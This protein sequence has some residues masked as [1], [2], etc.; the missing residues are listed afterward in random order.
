MR[1]NQIIC[2]KCK[3]SLTSKAGIEVGT[4]I[5]CPKCKSKFAVSAP[6]NQEEVYEDFEVVDDDEEETPKKRPA[7]AKPIAKKRDDDDEDDAPKRKPAAKPVAKKPADDEDSD[8]GFVNEVGEAPRKK[9]PQVKSAAN[10]RDEVDEDDDRPTPKKKPRR[11]E[12]EDDRPTAKKKV[13]RDDDE[14]DDDRP[15][16][17]KK[18]R[19]DDDEYDAPMS[20]RKNRDDDEDEVK[21]RR[22][23]RRGDDDDDDDDKAKSGYAKAKSN[24]WIRGGVLGGLLIIMGVLGYF[25]YDKYYGKKSGSSNDQDVEAKN[26]E[27]LDMS[28]FK[29]LPKDGELARFQ[30]SWTATQAT[31]EGQALPAEALAQL[32]ITI[33]GDKATS[34]TDPTDVNTLRINAGKSPAEVDIVDKDN[35]IQRAIYRF[36]DAN[37]LQICLQIIPGG[38]RPKEFSA[39][40]GSNNVLMTLKRGK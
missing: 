16:A 11:D 33:Q 7:P 12:D 24:P 19:R 27:P 9:A 18:A 5:P 35:K 17:K 22:N 28:R 2:P 29:N 1:V 23:K 3:T 40:K 26:R 32:A 21:P 38:Q 14:D 30:G 25:L 4:T 39:P 36:V 31:S 15:A 37:T 10:R 20:K 34:R 13:R 8:F 6:K